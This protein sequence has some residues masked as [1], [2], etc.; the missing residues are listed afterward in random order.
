MVLL[1]TCFTQFEFHNMLISRFKIVFSSFYSLMIDIWSEVCLF[2]NA[3][4]DINTTDD[5]CVG[6]E[7]DGLDGGEFS[8]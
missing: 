4:M 1:H 7:E 6:N 3:L 2:F 8:S 5:E